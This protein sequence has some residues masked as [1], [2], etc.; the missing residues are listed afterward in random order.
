VHRGEPCFEPVHHLGRRQ[1]DLTLDD[2]PI[3]AGQPVESRRSRTF[4]GE[5]LDRQ[6][7]A[8]GVR[9][10]TDL[11][12]RFDQRRRFDA[13]GGFGRSGVLDL[14]GTIEDASHIISV[15]SLAH[16]S[17]IRSRH[18]AHVERPTTNRCLTPDGRVRGDRCLTP[19]ST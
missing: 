10:D 11:G 5:P 12:R 9:I 3:R 13:I 17:T 14:L 7:I 16:R 2:H 18:H 1:R 19:I 6:R 15:E 4:D 8:H